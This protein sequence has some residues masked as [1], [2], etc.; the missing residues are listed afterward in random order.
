MKI[1][2]IFTGGTIGSRLGKE[3]TV[4][5]DEEMRFLLLERYRQEE[6]TCGEEEF[7]EFLTEEP[8]YILS[9]NLTAK[10]LLKLYDCILRM[11]EKEKPAGI[12]V[13]HGTDTLAYTAAFLSYVFWE[14]Q[15]PVVLVSSAYPMEDERA[16]GMDNFK[17]AVRFITDISVP[18]VYVSY[19]NA[20]E[21]V[22]IHAGT[23]ILH[24]LEYSDRVFCLRQACYGSFTEDW[25][26][27]KN[28]AY[29]EAE[30]FNGEQ[31]KLLS[32][33]LT[34]TEQCTEV[35]RIIPYVGMSYPVIGEGTRAVLM[36]SYHSGTIGI[37]DELRRFAKTAKERGVPVY[38]TG[39]NTEDADYE[40]VESYEALG[41]IPLRNKTAVSQYVK[42][43]LFLSND[44]EPTAYM[45]EKSD[46]ESRPAL[47]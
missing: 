8:Y 4:V 26:F 30:L 14:V 35:L 12:I 31:K 24:P 11:I 46:C 39:L 19:K 2:T 34:L 20:G 40:T 38:L 45:N 15:I 42:L 25:S 41:I 10:E 36:E 3:G 29:K 17:G 44:M 23:G 43:W 13:L 6:K 32:K 7:P 18:G 21:N 16:N 47:L 1:G 9:E 22:K 27:V 5:P 33:S 37:S 28:T